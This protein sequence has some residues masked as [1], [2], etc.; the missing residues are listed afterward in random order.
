MI[1]RLFGGTLVA[2]L[3][4]L[5]SGLLLET[6]AIADSSRD[7][8]AEGSPNVSATEANRLT[9]ASSQTLTTV[10]LEPSLAAMPVAEPLTDE[11]I[12]E[13]EQVTSVS[14]LTDVQPTDWAFQALQ[15]LVERY[16]CIVGYPDRTYRGNRAL[17]RYEFAA[18]LNACMDRISELIA[19]GTADL[20][21]KED[22]LAVQKMQEEF[23]AEL[24]TVRGR[25]GALEARSATLE[26]QQFSTTTKVGT[27]LIT[28]LADAFGDRA[29][30]LN[31]ANIGYRL[32]L[33]FDTS[34]TG[35]DRLRT[36]LQGTNLRKFNVGDVFG[37]SPVG[38]AT[39]D[40][41]DETRFLATST[42][43]NSEITLNRLQYRF[44]VGE[45]LTVFL[46]ANTIDPSIVTDPITPFNDQATGSLSNFAQ[47][48]PIW[49]PLGNQAG[50]AVNYAISPNF[51][52]DFGY[53]A[54]GGSPNDPQL[55]FFNAG[56]S[57]F[58]HLIVYSGTFKLGFFYMNSYSPQFGVDTLAGSNAAKIIG[59]GPVVGNGY[60]IELDY[61]INRWFELGGWVGL[62]QAR[63]LGTGT[64]GDANIW[65]FAINFAF[66]DL[67]KKGNL[68]GIVFGMQPK[69]TGTSNAALATAIGLPDGQREDRDTGYHI[70][71]FYRYQLT[72]NLSITPGFIWL[73][74]PNHDSR[75][76]DAV[77]GVIRTT[78]VF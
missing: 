9:P 21:K 66:P 26:Q 73:T 34:F 55:G 51:Q 41:S 7:V 2:T 1:T 67:G 36:R 76:P 25:V 61:R 62:T 20:V 38:R 71:A 33:D 3:A 39:S 32:R 30:P 54:E 45:K 5:S 70:E 35:K 44:P 42:S 19:A 50:V 8:S 64:R 40:L 75:N 49:F 37:A 16:G 4:L 46:D 43:S 23:A 10:A 29:D 31:N 13:M 14:Q 24:A 12:A 74:A 58:A 59:A 72:D 53:Q 6:P 47:I 17:T 69:L 27:E 11:S 65:N 48:N 60:S 28:Y 52:F 56:Y 15:S 18:G 77:I 68:G 63:T 78:F 57:A 22:L